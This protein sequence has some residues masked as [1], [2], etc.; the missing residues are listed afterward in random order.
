GNFNTPLRAKNTPAGTLNDDR[1]YTFEEEDFN[2]TIPFE[3]VYV[4][5]LIIG[6]AAF[7]E[8]G[9]DLRP[10]YDWGP[11]GNEGDFIPNVFETE[12]GGLRQVTP[13][14]GS[15]LQ[16]EYQ[17]EIR[18]ASDYAAGQTPVRTFD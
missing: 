17:L 2:F 3:G 4:D 1:L 8:R 15:I 14:P 6:F 18:R 10:D 16:G 12:L 11:V 7:G 5:D 9:V 13:P